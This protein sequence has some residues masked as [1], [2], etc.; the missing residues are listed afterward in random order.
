V[1]RSVGEPG[2]P[3]L[4]HERRYLDGDRSPQWTNV[5]RFEVGPDVSNDWS[6]VAPLHPIGGREGDAQS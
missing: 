2:V 3:F 1:C 5:S 4:Q 6:V